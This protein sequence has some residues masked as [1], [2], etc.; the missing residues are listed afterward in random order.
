ME[1]QFTNREIR[2]MFQD[3]HLGLGRIET[4]TKLTN[5]SVANINR[6]RE[7]VNGAFIASSAFMTMV[8]LPIL[9]WALYTILQVPI[10][11]HQAV[12]N[13]LQAYDI[14]AQNN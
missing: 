14:T 8:V 11:V 1:E 9:G 7:R 13:A 10:T 12:D 6:W 5:G 3:V 2:E 4:Q